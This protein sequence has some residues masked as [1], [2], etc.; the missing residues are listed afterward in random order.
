MAQ[1][2]LEVGLYVEKEA[3]PCG[4]LLGSASDKH[5]IPSASSPHLLMWKCPCSAEGM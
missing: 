3:Q 2:W 1:C 4:P 5:V